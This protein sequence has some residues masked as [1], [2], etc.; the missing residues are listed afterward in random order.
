M[1]WSLHTLSTASPLWIYAQWIMFIIKWMLFIGMMEP[2][3]CRTSQHSSHPTPFFSAMDSRKWS[4]YRVCFHFA[5]LSTATWHFI[6]FSHL[7]IFAVHSENIA[8]AHSLECTSCMNIS[9]INKW[10]CLPEFVFHMG[11]CLPKFNL[12]NIR[13]R[14]KSTCCSENVT[15]ENIN[16][17]D[18]CEQ[19]E[20]TCC[21][22]WFAFSTGPEYDS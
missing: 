18:G 3:N 4:F 14:V 1:L 21:C 2:M 17:V 20:T 8:I 11:N 10:I 13:I 12:P 5:L 22:I 19:E 16:T 9:W 6:I 7:R 15:E